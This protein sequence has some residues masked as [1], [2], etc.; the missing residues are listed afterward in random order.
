MGDPQKGKKDIQA[1]LDEFAGH[2]QKLIGMQHQELISHEDMNRIVSVMSTWHVS[3]FGKGK[4][5]TKME[6]LASLVGCDFRGTATQFDREIFPLVKEFVALALEATGN[7]YSA[8]E[9]RQMQGGGGRESSRLYEIMKSSGL[10]E[11]PIAEVGSEVVIH[12]TKQA[13]AANEILALQQKIDQ[14]L[15]KNVD[16]KDREEMRRFL[17]GHWYDPNKNQGKVGQ[18]R[19]VHEAKT[20]QMAVQAEVDTTNSDQEKRKF[21]AKQLE[22]INKIYND[23]FRYT[24][25]GSS[26][27]ELKKAANTAAQADAAMILGNADRVFNTSPEETDT[28]S[29]VRAKQS[30]LFQEQPDI[31]QKLKSSIEVKPTVA[32]DVKTLSGFW[33]GVKS[34]LNKLEGPFQRWKERR[35]EKTRNR[36]G[37]TN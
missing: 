20:G 29:K 27:T 11:K 31:R 12:L 28:E 18:L 37:P 36:A 35:E 4:P 17:M 22:A 1:L 23:V 6:D 10:S 30:Q 5:V 26:P 19:D 15:D 8:Y 32:P 14:Y 9:V 25:E 7:E 16:E 13:Q 33:K 2:Q 21:T 34:F 3:S 24:P